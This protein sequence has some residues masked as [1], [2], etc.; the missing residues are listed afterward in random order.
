M[1]V[2]VLH[3]AD[4][5]AA[6]VLQAAARAYPNEACGLIEGI[7]TKGGWRA[8]FIHEAANVADDPA[9]RFLIDPQVQFA[10]MRK[11]RGSEKRI[12]GCFHSHP[13]GRAE[14]SATDRANAYESD[15]VYVIAAGAHGVFELKAWLFSD[16][17]GF[18]ELTIASP[19]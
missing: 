3:L 19:D 12:I 13:N 6:A 17:A 15:F 7:D 8:L 18:S 1:S 2:R 9:R 10:L 14:P 16:G 4:E 11:L 5:L